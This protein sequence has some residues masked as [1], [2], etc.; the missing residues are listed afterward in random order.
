MYRDFK[1]KVLLIIIII[2]L[3]IF[4]INNFFPAITIH[5]LLVFGPFVLVLIYAVYIPETQFYR[6][7]KI[8]FFICFSLFLL[9]Y[10]TFKPAKLTLEETEYMQHFNAGYECFRSRDLECSI[11]EYELAENLFDTDIE[12]YVRKAWT[13]EKMKEHEKA[14]ECANKA[15]KLDEKDSIYKK[16]NGFRIGLN[17]DISIYTTIGDCNYKLKKYEEAKTAYNYVINHI[18]Y[19]YSDVY[20]KRGRCEYYLGNKTSALKDFYKHKNIINQYLEEEAK[21][22]YP[23]K[24]PRYTYRNLEKIDGWIKATMAL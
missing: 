24:Y 6:N 15:L 21:S 9:S 1:L 16:A 11:R 2:L 14:I 7:I 3:A 10:F 20:F 23:A 18:I 13:Y 5:N 19:K 12:L 17:S 22:E 4:P 8:G